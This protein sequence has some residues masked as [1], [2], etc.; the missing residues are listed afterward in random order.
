MRR[1]AGQPCATVFLVGPL[2]PPP[3]FRRVVSARTASIRR[4]PTSLSVKKRAPWP[5]PE[6][7]SF[8]GPLAMSADELAAFM[9]PKDKAEV[10]AEDEAARADE[11]YW[12]LFREEVECIRQLRTLYPNTAQLAMSAD[13]ITEYY[14][15]ATLFPRSDSQRERDRKFISRLKTGPKAKRDDDYRLLKRECVKA[16][17]GD[18]RRARTMFLNLA[19]ERLDAHWHTAQNAWSLL[20]REVAK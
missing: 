10:G 11:E 20:K 8:R 5:S 14:R 16:C 19:F 1:P 13:E 9:T 12:R 2:S 6:E 4:R 7:G 17:R 3:Q 15:R 18:M